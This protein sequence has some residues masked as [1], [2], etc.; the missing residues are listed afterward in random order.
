[1]KSFKDYNL[2]DNLLHSLEKVNYHSPTEIQHKSIDII[3][4]GS[5]LLASSKTGSGKT[6]AFIIPLIA[7][8]AQYPKNN[9]ALII[10]P[11]RELVTQIFDTAKL[12]TSKNIRCCPI[13][14]GVDMRK[15]ISNLRRRPNIIIATPG[16]IRD[17]ISRET[18]D[19]AKINHFILDEFDRMLDMGFKDDIK[20]IYHK[21]SD[22]R[23]V[24]MFSATQSKEIVTL[25]QNYLSED[26]KTVNIINKKENNKNITH[27]FC[28]LASDQKFDNLIKEI[29]KK[30][31]ST[32]IFVNTKR[33]A[34]KLQELLQENGYKSHAIHGDLRQHKRDRIIKKFRSKYYQIL[35]ATDVVA[36]GIDIDHIENVINYD[37]PRTIE[38]YIHRV[39]RTGRMH[40]KGNALSF[41]SNI[42]KIV[43]NKVISELKLE[44]KITFPTRKYKKKK[45]FR[46]KRTRS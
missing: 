2:P 28:Y 31:G 6:A 8:I 7:K 5:D 46:K 20:H 19:I 45:V 25:A 40:A 4:S 43:Y 38:D 14:G 21:L 26:Y 11:T 16:R 10:A 17:H 23:Q 9:F 13:V 15:Q 22:K 30:T 27:D 35:I 32:L 37:F 39:G 44:N 18:I 34:D 33:Y 36:R 42:D 24:I 3:L 29:D 12:I 1:M 41:I